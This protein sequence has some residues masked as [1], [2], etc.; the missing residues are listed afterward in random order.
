VLGR[1]RQSSDGSLKIT[2]RDVPESE[3]SLTFTE[4][5]APVPV[6]ESRAQAE[7]AALSLAVAGLARGM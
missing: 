2:G 3:Y 5:K 4:G 6:S 7:A 1:K